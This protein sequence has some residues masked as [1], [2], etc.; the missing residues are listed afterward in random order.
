MSRANIIT[1]DCVDLFG[2]LAD[3][4][5]DAI[6][7]DPP[8]GLGFMGKAFDTLGPGAAQQAWHYRW[9]VEA[10]RVLK[11]GGHLLAFGGSRTSHRLACA[12]EDAA[13]EIRD[14]VIWIYGSGFPKSLNVSKA[15]DKAAGAERAVV[16]K[17][18]SWNRPEST[19][20]NVARM[21]ASPG[22]YD[23]TTPTTPAAKTW[24]GYGT[25]LKPAHEPCV[26]A[27]KPLS[28]T[29]AGNVQAHGVGAL[30]ID[31]CRAG[32]VDNY[33][34]PHGAGGCAFA[35]GR[36]PDVP[37]CDTPAMHAAGRW[38]ANVIHDG[39][40]EVLRIFPETGP[41]VGGGYGGWQQDGYVGGDP[42]AR[43]PRTCHTATGSAARFFYCAKAST[44]ERHAGVGRNIHPTVKPVAL[45]R[46]LCRLVA[47]PGGLVLD[48]FTGSGSTAIAALCEGMRFVGFELDPAYADIA[49]ARVAHWFV[50]GPADQ[51]EA[52]VGD[53]TT[54][55]Q[56]ALF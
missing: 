49:R 29:V 33:A 12:V 4:S 14:S 28:G 2:D 9:A 16:G 13:F 25:A 36:S 42:G 55:D 51:V 56:L 18:E 40:D 41:S 50:E 20:G 26:M 45:M 31:G 17:R 1:G 3:E 47:P 44:A 48:P 38:P 19:D 39:T 34:Y 11:P 37:P 24:Q 8:Y 52:R 10:L 22:I 21:N 35:V 30:N 5:I 53:P 54:P 46:H 15:I 32:T 27:R 7:C 6:V 43:V 23:L